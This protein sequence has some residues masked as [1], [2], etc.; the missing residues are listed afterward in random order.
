M[1]S[2]LKE[3]NR[4]SGA[5]DSTKYD[6]EDLLFKVLVIGDFGVGKTSLIRRYTEGV[7]NPAYKITIGVDFSLKHL[8]W[9]NKKHITL[10]LWYMLP[11]ACLMA[12]AVLFDLASD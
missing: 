4:L 3:A 8:V 10:Q 11:D 6:I 2:S 5:F 9:N 12:T 7:F 1:S